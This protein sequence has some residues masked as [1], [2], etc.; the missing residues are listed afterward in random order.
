MKKIKVDG[1][2][3]IEFKKQLETINSLHDEICNMSETRRIREKKLWEHIKKEFPELS[4][5]SVASIQD[6]NFY[7]IDRL[8]D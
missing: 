3:S 8:S 7:I 4:D 5:N 1:E 6:G 2:L